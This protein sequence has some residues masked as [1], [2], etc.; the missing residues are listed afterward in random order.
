M[1]NSKVAHVV[2]FRQVFGDLVAGHEGLAMVGVTRDGEV[3]WVSTSLTRD[4]TVSGSQRLSLAQ[5]LRAAAADVGRT[6]RVA[7]VQVVE[8]TDAN[9]FTRVRVPGV[10]DTQYAPP[11]RAAHPHPGRP[12]GVGDHPAR[13]RRTAADHGPEAFIS[14]VDAEDGTVLFRQNRV[15]HFAAPSTQAVP[16]NPRWKVFPANPAIADP[17]VQGSTPATDERETW[18]WAPGDGCDLVVGNTASRTPWD[19]DA[20]T[21][22]STFTTTG[23]N[24]RTAPSL[25]QLPDARR[26]RGPAVSPPATYDFAFTNQWHTAV[27]RPGELRL[28]RQ[29]NDIDAA[30]VNLFVGHNRMHDWSYFLGFTE[31]NCNLQTHNFGNAE[32]DAGVARG[33]ER[34][35]ARP[36]PGR[37]GRR[38]PDLPGPRQR[39]PDHAAGRHPRHHQPVPLAA[40][41]G[42]LLRPLRRR[43]LR[44][45]VIAPRVRPR[46]PEPHGRRPGRRPRPAPQGGSMGESWSDLTAIEYLNGYGYAGRR[47]R[48]P[49][50]S[51]PTSPVTR[52]PASATTT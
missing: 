48:T 7:D 44:P 4:S 20:R 32:T 41:A 11:A 14:F 5:A 39:Q 31:R 34:P 43:R 22:L 9:G 3:T 10:E 47:A 40:A 6:V 30:T 26:R 18:C 25:R 36:E 46:D 24:A 29:R 28:A 49:S 35:G 12:S 8:Q 17:A 16:N 1:K 13:H 2:L 15:D 19:V 50:P 37:R 42:R 45:S 23:N 51:A 52:S 38:R 27:V 33:R 21:G